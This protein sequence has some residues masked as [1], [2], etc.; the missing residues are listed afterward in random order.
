MCNSLSSAWVTQ[1]TTVS[2]VSAFGQVVEDLFRGLHVPAESSAT[3]LGQAEHC[4]RLLANEFLFHA[5][6]A[7][8]FQHAQV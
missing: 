7:G 8:G 6:I 4:V 5:D 1:L 2:V 3:F